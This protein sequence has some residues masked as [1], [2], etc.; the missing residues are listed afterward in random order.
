MPVILQWTS[1]IKFPW[2]LIVGQRRE[3]VN[4]PGVGVF[5]E[6]WRTRMSEGSSNQERNGLL[7]LWLENI[8]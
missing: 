7:V 4:D 3:G 8:C 5:K 2:I 1:M 6:G